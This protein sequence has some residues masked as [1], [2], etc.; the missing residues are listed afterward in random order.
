MSKRV[1]VALAVL[2]LAA[3]FVGVQPHRL[4]VTV[5]EDES[6]SSTRFLSDYYR[7]WVGAQ[8]LA[9]PN[10]FPIGVFLQD[11]RRERNGRA[12]GDNYA[13][14]GFNILVGVWEE[15]S[16]E[17][18]DA[19]P[20]GMYVM[21]SPQGDVAMSSPKVIGYVIADEP[22]LPLHPEYGGCILPSDLERLVEE[23]HTY[24][25][26]RPAYVNFGRHIAYPG[27]YG[28]HNC[29]DTDGQ[30]EWNRA[31]EGKLANQIDPHD[32]VTNF[33]PDY[34]HAMEYA[35]LEP[36]DIASVDHYATTD[37]YTHPFNQQPWGY[38][39]MVRR[40]NT[41]ARGKPGWAFIQVTEIGVESQ[42]K[43]MPHEIRGFVWLSLINGAQGIEYFVHCFAP[44]FI[45]DCLLED[46]EMMAAVKA[47]NFQIRALAPILNTPDSPDTP[48]TETGAGVD[49]MAKVY[50]HTTYVFAV[51]SRSGPSEA[52][53]TV[54]GAAVEVLGEN[55][56][57]PVIDGQFS[58]HFDDY[59]VHLYRV[60]R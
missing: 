48:H 27:Y 45:E 46:P 47:V 33:I 6:A 52:T 36:V 30:E 11:P 57:I 38:G 22:D 53:F 40:M 18:L 60:R 59:T 44:R 2:S 50:D 35:W 54:D 51:G 20:E 26:T 5:T 24:D 25:S 12:N 7:Q 14:L 8:P 17:H 55:R 15:L 31:M 13:E 34:D 39:R 43:P 29:P 1:I 28:G 42:G 41:F 32:P 16:Q 19:V 49:V 21:P 37:V 9:D 58:D 23:S 56:T 3:L 10:F 4:G